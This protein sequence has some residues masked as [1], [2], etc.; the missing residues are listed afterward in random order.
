[1][2]WLDRCMCIYDNRDM[3]VLL[4]FMTSI[5]EKLKRTEPPR[6]DRDHSSS[7]D[8]SLGPDVRTAVEKVIKSSPRVLPSLMSEDPFN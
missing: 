2:C 4:S 6:P 1:M 3:I 8:D 7:R 5:L